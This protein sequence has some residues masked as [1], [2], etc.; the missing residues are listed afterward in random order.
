MPQREKHSDIKPSGPPG[1][2]R[3]GEMIRCILCRHLRPATFEHS[4]PESCGNQDPVM[5]LDWTAI[6][7]YV[8]DTG[9]RVGDAVIASTEILDKPEFYRQQVMQRGHGYHTLCGE[10]NTKL[11]V[12]NPSLK[13]WEQAAHSGQRTDGISLQGDFYMLRVIKAI[14]AQFF[15]ANPDVAADRQVARLLRHRCNTALPSPYRL[16][17]YARQGTMLRSTGFFFVQKKPGSEPH[18]F[19]EFHT[20]AIGYVVSCDGEKYHPDFVELT[21]FARRPF[22]K[23]ET[24]ELTLPYL[25][26]LT[27]IPGDFRTQE[28]RDAGERPPQIMYGRSGAQSRAHFKK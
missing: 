4:P 13:H 2:R 14:M 16:F 3:R 18:V 8:A 25:P 17:A 6:T 24:V 22:G 19:S 20:Q 15:S 1:A 9:P 11:G 5:A 27:P 26:V 21:H 10:C 7:R 12:Y 23:L 28:Q